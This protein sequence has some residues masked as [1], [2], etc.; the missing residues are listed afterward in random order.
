[1]LGFP[2]RP[3]SAPAPGPARRARRLARLLACATLFG[4]GACRAVGGAGGPADPAAGRPIGVAATDFAPIGVAP[5]DA[6]AADL[7]PDPLLDPPLDPLAPQDRFEPEPA[8]QVAS[9]RLRLWRR[10]PGGVGFGDIATLERDGRTRV[11]LPEALTIEAS[12][13]TDLDGDGRPEALVRTWS[14]G[15]H[16]CYGI[17]AF[18]L[19][20]T[21]EPLL[22]TPP[23]S[24][25]GRFQDLDGD[26]RQELLT[27]DDAFGYAFCPFAASPLPRVVLRYAPEQGVY[28]P[29]TP[30]FAAWLAAD[31]SGGD[32]SR[33][34]AGALPADAAASEASDPDGARPPAADPTQERC[35]AL[36]PALAAL[37]TGQAEAGWQAIADIAARTGAPELRS[38]VERILA[39]SAFY[40]APGAIAAPV[41]DGG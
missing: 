38:E 3:D 28:I 36:G 5:T 17:Q 40:L 2:R 26:G 35:A 13:A 23:S 18:R 16:C 24:C 20:E 21:A 31:A 9:W 8:S 19:A 30:D 25:D 33:A 11:S 6:G 14:G 39:G 22:R 37:Y 12:A 1:M 7:G 29:A 27:C 41:L 10:Q 15:A 34:G 32:T 4:L